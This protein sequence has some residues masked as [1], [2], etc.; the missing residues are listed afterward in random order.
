[1]RKTKIED[2]KLHD[3][4]CVEGGGGDKNPSCMKMRICSRS[5]SPYPFHG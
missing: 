2:Q 3:Y 1:M 4:V 5:Y